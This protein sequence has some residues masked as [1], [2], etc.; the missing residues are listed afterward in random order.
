VF[1]VSGITVFQLARAGFRRS[2]AT[3]LYL[4]AP[5]LVTT[6]AVCPTTP[7]GAKLASMVVS[8]ATSG[9]R[10]LGACALRRS[11]TYRWFSGSVPRLTLANSQRP[12]SLTCA[13]T[14]HVGSFG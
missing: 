3:S 5:R 1:A 4:G 11:A 9:A 12:S 8:M 14:L 7:T 2:T 6:Y 13:P 10:R